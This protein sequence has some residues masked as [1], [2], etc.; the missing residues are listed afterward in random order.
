MNALKR[1]RRGEKSHAGCAELLILL[2]ACRSSCSALVPGPALGSHANR[3][4]GLRGYPRA[5]CL[6]LRRLCAFPSPPSRGQIETNAGYAQVARTTKENSKGKMML[7]RGPVQYVFGNIMV[8]CI[9]EHSLT[10][11]LINKFKCENTYITYCISELD[12]N[13]FYKVHAV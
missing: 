13:A 7:H 5:S 2:P 3:G 6:L 1:W 11:S 4:M 12:V 8:F 9:C 10:L